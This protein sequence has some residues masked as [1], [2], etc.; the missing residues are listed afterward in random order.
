MCWPR[1]TRQPLHF[2]GAFVVQQLPSTLGTMPEWSASMASSGSRHSRS[3]STH[4]TRSL[5]PAVSRCSR[6]RS[7]RSSSI[8]PPSAQ[9]ARGPL[10]GL[11][12]KSRP[13]RI[14]VR[15]ERPCSGRLL[16]RRA[17]EAAEAHQYF[18]D[19]INSWLENADELEVSAKLLVDAVS[20]QLEIV[21]IRL[22]ATEDAQAIFETLNARGEPLSAADPHQEA[23]LPESRRHRSGSRSS[24]PQ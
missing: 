6:H 18:S 1:K 3:S 24:V 22:D 11:A 8:R 21:S 19:S 5:T 20:G 16:K 12:D 10:Q 14:Q 9:E 13:T 15:H 4:F 7:S 23:H 17:V 2:L